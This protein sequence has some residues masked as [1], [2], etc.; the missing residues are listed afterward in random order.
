MRGGGEVGHL[1][2]PFPVNRCV[3]LVKL[4]KPH[5]YGRPGQIVRVDE[6][7]ARSFIE[8]GIAEDPGCVLVKHGLLEVVNAPKME[9]D[10]ATPRPRKRRKRKGAAK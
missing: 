10:G 7:V 3:M 9:E 4:C 6:R 8:R 2:A 1:T 5:G